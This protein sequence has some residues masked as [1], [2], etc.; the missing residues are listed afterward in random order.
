MVTV[1][2]SLFIIV[3]RMPFSFPLELPKD[4]SVNLFILE[5]P[6][7]RSGNHTHKSGELG[8]NPDRLPISV[9]LNARAWHRR[10]ACRRTQVW[11]SGTDQDPWLAVSC[12]GRAPRLNI[13]TVTGVCAPL[14]GKV[15][16]HFKLWGGDGVDRPNEPATLGELRGFFQFCSK[17]FWTAVFEEVGGPG[18]RA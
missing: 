2:K 5:M 17:R 4:D 9:Q 7:K 15:V 18:F 8:S 16:L 1:A 3:K 13:A 6:L 10:P 12:N 14:D 11:R